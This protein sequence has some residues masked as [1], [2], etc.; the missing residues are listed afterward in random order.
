MEPVNPAAFPS[1]SFNAS[2]PCLGTVSKYYG[3]I[4]CSKFRKCA[5]FELKKRIFLYDSNLY[6]GFMLQKSNFRL[7]IHDA[8]KPSIAYGEIFVRVMSRIGLGH[9]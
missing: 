3:L 2:H 5:K 4:G 7:V 9:E 8:K 6:N 1:A